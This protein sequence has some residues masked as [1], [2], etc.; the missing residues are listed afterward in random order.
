MMDKDIEKAVA[1][2]LT[3]AGVFNLND[4]IRKSVYPEPYR[5]KFYRDYMQ[6]RRVLTAYFEA[7]A[8][9][10]DDGTQE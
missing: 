1:D 6:A 8:K 5:G 9:E 10:A 3:V 4:V 2:L 7:K